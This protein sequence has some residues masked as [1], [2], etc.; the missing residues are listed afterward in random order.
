MNVEITGSCVLIWIADKHLRTLHT[1]HLQCG[2]QKTLG[3][4]SDVGQK[5]KAM[6]R[7]GLYL[8]F[9]ATSAIKLVN[10]NC[11]DL[12]DRQSSAKFT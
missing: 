12:D 8:H 11:L 4:L 5:Y 7:N 6:Y 1:K 2:F 9:V 10:C 3:W